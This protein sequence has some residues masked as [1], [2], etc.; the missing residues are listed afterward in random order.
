VK[1]ASPIG[2]SD[3]LIHSRFDNWAAAALDHFD[4]GPA[5]VYA[6]D[7]MPH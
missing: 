2:L 1:L 7:P 6:N 5:Y 4:L 3:H